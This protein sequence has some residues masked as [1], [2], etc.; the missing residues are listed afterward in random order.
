[1]HLFITCT[2]NGGGSLRPKGAM[3]TPDFDCFLRV[4]VLI[5]Q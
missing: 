5:E 1:L 4:I 2:R 3:A